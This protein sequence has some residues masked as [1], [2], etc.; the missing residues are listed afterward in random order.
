MCPTYVGERTCTAGAEC[1][2]RYRGGMS[3]EIPRKRLQIAQLKVIGGI[4]VVVIAIGLW[5]LV[6]FSVLFAFIDSVDWFPLAV[7]AVFAVLA[8]ALPF[9]A[10]RMINDG[11]REV[12]AM[13]EAVEIEGLKPLVGEL[14]HAPEPL[15]MDQVL[16]A[17]LRLNEFDLPYSLELERDGDVATVTVQWRVEELR[18]R[19]LLTRGNQV[20]RWRMPVRLDGRS[21]TYSF[22]ELKSMSTLVGS[23]ATASLSGA[24][25]WSR[26]K[27]MG[28]GSVTKVWAVGVVDSPE[29]TGAS[30]RIRIVPSD[31]K[32]PVFAILRSHG[33]RPKR[34]SLFW[35]QWEF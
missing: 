27:T 19:T 15:P 30:G 5:I 24:K 23:G 4:G 20:R 14:P 28:A 29:G 11:S 21:G 10:L 22:T 8:M 32:V 25:S 18:W 34:D 35:R 16:E 7:T 26:G 1:V 2:E 13:Q 33:W 17:L 31:A 9:L 12:I 3:D 6:F